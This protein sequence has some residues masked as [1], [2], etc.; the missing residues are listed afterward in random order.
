MTRRRIAYVCLQATEQ[1]QASHAHVHEI[2]AGLQRRGWD[3]TLYEPRYAGTGSRPPQVARLAAF[4]GV[5]VRFGLRSR[6]FDAI[7][8]RDHPAALLAML[9]ARLMR[10]P[11]LLEMNGAPDE[12]FL[13]YPWT[14]SFGWLVR[15]A[16]DARIRAASAVIT[17]TEDLAGWV[18]G[19]PGA[20]TVT[21]IPNGADPARFR[22]AD[23]YG[24]GHPYVAFA[25]VLAVWQG[26]EVLLRATRSESWPAGVVLKI[27]GSGMC[28]SLVEAAQGESPLIEYVGRLSY[29]AVPGF[30]ARSRA[31]LSPQVHNAEREVRPRAGS[32]YSGATYSMSPVKLYE[33]MACG[34]PMVVTDVPG[35]AEIVREADCGI[36]VSPGDAEALAVAIA[37]II[38]DPDAAAAMG[39]RGREAVVARHSWDARAEATDRVIA[40]SIGNE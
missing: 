24:I 22:P 4:L 12:L 2:I 27:A 10:R 32:T 28:Q 26:L 39:R 8:V 35:Q 9:V 6:R 15:W 31:A 36:V 21:A 1:G 16:S 20:T 19:L 25:G 13:S 11:V 40:E 7:Y 3:V 23:P 37:Q 14:R 17:N 5:Q 38:A 33:G 29:D 18:R 30:L 34:I